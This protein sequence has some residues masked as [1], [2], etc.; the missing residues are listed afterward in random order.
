M[1]TPTSIGVTTPLKTRPHGGTVVWL[2]CE[3]EPC[4]VVG[5]GVQQAA[6]GAGLTYKQ[7]TTSAGN[8]ATLISAMNQALQMSPKPLAVAFAGY[9]EAVWS[10]MVPKFQAA[11]IALVPDG[12]GPVAPSP[13]VP[14]LSLNGPSDF[15]HQTS[16]L[17]NYFVADSKGSGKALL[18]NIADVGAFA[19]MKAEF[20]SAVQKQCP[21]CTVSSI[22]ITT[23]QLGSN[24]VVPAI[25]SALQANPSINYVVTPEGDAVQ[26]LS[27][28]AAAAGLS[29]VK[30]LSLTPSIVTEQ[31]LQNGQVQASVALPLK[32]TGWKIVDTALRSS[33]GM[34]V[35]PGDGGMPV[36]LFTQQNLTAPAGSHDNPANYAAEF[37]KLWGL[38]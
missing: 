16:D 5:Q 1:Q 30:V 12:A 8:P 28:A 21:S 31:G 4:Q 25:V 14:A 9:P 32:M 3:L 23:S 35:T 18:L 2:T 34:T 6:A 13:A 38:G 20:T 37:K 10:T 33:E 29:K 22:N 19:P 26:G 7:I 11:K 27:S 17:A 24:G 15:A 36:Q